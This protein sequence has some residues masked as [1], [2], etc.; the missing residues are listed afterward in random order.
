MTE[1]LGDG[2]DVIAYLQLAVTRACEKSPSSV[3][4]GWPHY[5]TMP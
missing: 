5:N 3:K 4:V 1:K 2:N